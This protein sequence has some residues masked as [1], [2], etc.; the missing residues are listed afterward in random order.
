MCHSECAIHG[1]NDA[2]VVDDMGFPYIVT[3]YGDYAVTSQS[4][5]NS[6]EMTPAEAL[7]LLIRLEEYVISGDVG[8]IE[9]IAS[10]VPVLTEHAVWKV[11]M[12]SV[13]DVYETGQAPYSEAS[14][15]DKAQEVHRQLV[16]ALTA[17]ETFGL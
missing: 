7:A 14:E 17:G 5:P 16:V 3:Y 12:G 4:G 15:T 13:S 1:R 11:G 2:N 10:V 8:G 9:A 6:S